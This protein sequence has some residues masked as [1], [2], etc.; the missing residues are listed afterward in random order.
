MLTLR[1]RLIMLA[2]LPVGVRT[3]VL[4]FLIPVVSLRQ[5]NLL[6]SLVLQLAG[7][8]HFLVAS[9]LH[10]HRIAAALHDS[11]IIGAPDPRLLH[12]R[13]HRVLPRS[14]LMKLGLAV[15][16]ELAVTNM[17]RWDSGFRTTSPVLASSLYPSS[18]SRW[19]IVPL[20]AIPRTRSGLLVCSSLQHLVD[21][22][23][24]R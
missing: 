5:E 7:E 3:C 17:V 14:S 23:V 13:L 21:V 8:F 22:L 15:K 19:Q 6:T 4:K 2:L 10:E 1:V 12:S 9:V 18:C 16:S 20:L 11:I 24:L